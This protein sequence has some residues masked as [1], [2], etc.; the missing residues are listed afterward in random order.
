MVTEG[1]AWP[2]CDSDHSRPSS[3]GVK[4]DL[5]LYLPPPSVSM[6]CSVDPPPPPPP[7]QN[8]YFIPLHE[9]HSGNFSC[10][11]YGEIFKTASEIQQL[12]AAHTNQH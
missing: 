7:T 4:N 1:K 8:K 12:Y 6:A 3:A 2:G 5:E 9:N 10:H 11:L